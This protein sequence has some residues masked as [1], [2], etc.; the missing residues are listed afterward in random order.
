MKIPLFFFV[1]FLWSW[2]CW[3]IPAVSGASIASGAGLAFFGTGLLGPAVGAITIVYRGGDRASIA[4]YWVRVVDVRRIGARGW[5]T[6]VAIFPAIMLVTLFI[7]QMIH[8]GHVLQDARARFDQTFFGPASVVVLLAGV[9]LRGPL[10]EELGWRGAVLDRLQARFG[11]AGSALLLGGFWAA[12]HVPLFFLNGMLHQAQ[13]VGSAWFW[14][15]M[16]QVV[17]LSVLFSWIYN[18]TQRS[19]LAA[20]LAHFVA[21]VSMMLGNVTTGTNTIATALLLAV[22]VAVLASRPQCCLAPLP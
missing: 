19:T 8:G 7:A 18:R 22:A 1:T 21:N 15:F 3:L 17:C 13:G 4:D 5:L 11:F 12:W 14:Q 10:P 2:G 16:L 6:L 9:M 20:I